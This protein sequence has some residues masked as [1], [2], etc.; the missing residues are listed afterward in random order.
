MRFYIGHCKLGTIIIDGDSYFIYRF[1]GNKTTLQSV[2]QK[3]NVTQSSV[4]RI[5]DRVMEFLLDMGPDMIK[6]PNTTEQ[7]RKSEVAF[8]QVIFQFI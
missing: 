5:M 6:F 8:R 3:F 1:A 7:K 2:G 4:F